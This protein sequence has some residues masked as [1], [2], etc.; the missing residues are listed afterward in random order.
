MLTGYN[1]KGRMSIEKL[2]LVVKER[3]YQSQL[4]QNRIEEIS[5]VGS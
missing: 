5:N 2:P 3:E 4:Y 1:G